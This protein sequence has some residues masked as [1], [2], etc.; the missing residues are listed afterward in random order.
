MMP[1]RI[2][3]VEGISSSSADPIKA[4]KSARDAILFAVEISSSMMAAPSSTENGSVDSAA[5]ATLK[6]AYLL[7]QQRIISSPKD[8]MGILLYGTEKTKFR[9]EEHSQGLAYPN[10]YLLMDLNI[11]AA[12]DV[13]ALRRLVAEAEEFESFVKPSTKPASMANVLF[14]ANQIFTTKAPNIT[15]R[16]LFLVTDEDDPHADAKALKSTANVRAKDLYDLGV[17][18]ELFPIS[19][20]NSEFNRAK[21]YEVSFRSTVGRAN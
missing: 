2:W 17:T 1:L 13:K 11:P 15:S 3:Y 7:M 10:C 8:M 5:M 4:Y 16:R 6:C 18:I 9:E 12:A 14:C 19:K 20:S 21:F